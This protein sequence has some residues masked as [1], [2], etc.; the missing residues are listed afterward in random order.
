MPAFES[1]R[2]ELGLVTPFTLVGHSMGAM[3]AA[4]Y[5]IAYPEFVG[6]LVLASPAG[7]PVPPPDEVSWA[8]D[9]DLEPQWKL[10]VWLWRRG[11][12]PFTLVRLAG[13]FARLAVRKALMQRLEWVPETSASREA[14]Q[15][16]MATWLSEYMF[17][18]LCGKGSGEGAMV[19]MLAPA[20]SFGVEPL[21][22]KLVADPLR[23]PLTF[24]CESRKP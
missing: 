7:V 15:E 19:T 10:M 20:S 5:T 21:G 1:W 6:H 16:P 22:P 4:E 11:W 13:P 18:N 8:D 24:I 23:C 2:Q 17:Q 14:L 12:T 3:L 9:P